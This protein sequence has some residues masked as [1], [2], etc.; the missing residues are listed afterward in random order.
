M[1]GTTFAAHTHCGYVGE[2]ECPPPPKRT[3]KCDAVQAEDGSVDGLRLLMR[4][5]PPPDKT[6]T[7]T[8]ND[9]EH[10]LKTSAELPREALV[11]GV[12]AAAELAPRILGRAERFCRGV[13][14]LPDDQ[15][16]L[17]HGLH[18]LAAA[19]HPSLSQHL[20][21]LIRQPEGDLEQLFPSRVSTGLT[22]LLLSV[23]DRPQDELLWLIE[24][25]DIAGEARIALYNV[26][27]R[28]TFE[29]KIQRD[30]TLAFLMRVERDDLHQDDILAWWGWEDVVCHLGL[31][32]LE[33]ALE[34]VWTRPR[35]DFLRPRDREDA[36]TRMRWAA[37]NPTDATEFDADDVRPITDPVEAFSWIV[38]RKEALAAWDDISSDAEVETDPA[39]SIQLNDTDIEWLAGFLGSRQVPATTLSREQLDGFLTALVIGPDLVTPSEYLP[40]VWGTEDGSGPVWESA[41]QANYVMNLLMRHWNAIAA[42]RAARAEQRPLVGAFCDGEAWATGFLEAVE[43]RDEAWDPIFK[44]RR[45][46]HIV[47]PILALSGT[48]PAEVYEEFDGEVRQ[49]VIDELPAML[50]MI[51]AYW[52]DPSN[53]R[54]RQEPLRSAKIGRNEPCPCGSGKKY[55]KCCGNSPTVH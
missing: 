9:I 26:L 40:V 21:E 10:A 1:T 45:L 19:R 27:A 11:A 2:R 3:Q 20:L 34:R 24:H 25:A 12:G 49:D 28:Q 13:Y 32:E 36:L 50:Q 35:N 29:G 30:V 46:D 54:G 14:L 15:N 51:S 17:V 16:V 42:R 41:D 53:R 39:G 8:L 38:A 37:E 43:M 18:I 33:P 5:S 48:A 23:W 47:L 7:M 52:L 6:G 4:T 44:D 31:I 22:R 55:K